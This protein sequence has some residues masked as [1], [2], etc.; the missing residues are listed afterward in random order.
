MFNNEAL[1]MSWTFV[2]YCH[3]S[4]SFYNMIM[5]HAHDAR[6]ATMWLASPLKE[7]IIPYKKKRN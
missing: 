1:Q 4:I 6:V 7:L 2:L 5:T 3:F